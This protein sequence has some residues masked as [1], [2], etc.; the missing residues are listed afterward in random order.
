MIVFLT[1]ELEF[2]RSAPAQVSPLD[3]NSLMTVVPALCRRGFA[4]LLGIGFDARG[5]VR[6]ETSK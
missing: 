5:S 1:M 2:R 6:V 3:H 4:K